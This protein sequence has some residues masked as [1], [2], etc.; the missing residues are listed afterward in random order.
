MEAIRQARHVEVLQQ[1]DADPAHAQVRSEL[2]RMDWQ[3][4]LTA[5]MSGITAPAT[6]ISA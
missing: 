3:M 2:R 4:I 1:T 5:L 6:S